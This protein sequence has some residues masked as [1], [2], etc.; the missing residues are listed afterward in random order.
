[1]YRSDRI[2]VRGLPTTGWY[3]RNWRLPA[4]ERGTASSSSGRTRRRLVF[5]RRDEAP[6][7]LPAE[8]RGEAMP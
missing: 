4:R 6:P 3:R 1:M 7:C 5:L 8:G 2:P